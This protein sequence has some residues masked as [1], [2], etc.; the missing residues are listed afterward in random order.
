[1]DT[2]KHV[3]IFLIL[4]GVVIGGILLAIIVSLP[5]MTVIGIGDSI[6]Q[7]Y[8]VTQSYPNN[9]D[10]FYQNDQSSCLNQSDILYQ[11]DQ[12]SYLYFLCVLYPDDKMINM[13]RGG[14]TTNGL[15][16]R[17]NNVTPQHPDI[18]IFMIGTNDVFFN[19]PIDSV[20][21]NL[22]MMVKMAKNTG[23][24]PVIVTQIP[25]KDLN[26]DQTRQL[27][28]L[29]NL[30]RKFAVNNNVILV[31]AYN[32]FYDPAT[33]GLNTSVSNDGIH[34]NSNGAKILA[35]TIDKTLKNAKIA[36]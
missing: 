26:K 16:L 22:A 10:I 25:R 8:I 19:K 3:D 18:V 12:P 36:L 21:N 5:P 31:D 4:W 33:Y 20:M 13:G 32:V 6:T 11:N 9:P 34:P 23:S 1:M 15:M 24:I 14:D 17:Y 2:I 30:Y 29:N 7:G 27:L 35:G 28:E